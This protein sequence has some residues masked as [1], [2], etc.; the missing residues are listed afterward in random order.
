VRRGVEGEF[1]S[2][3]K[4]VSMRKAPSRP[5]SFLAEAMASLI[6]SGTLMAKFRGGSPTPLDE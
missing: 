4:G 2:H 5:L 3:V 1:T 6:A